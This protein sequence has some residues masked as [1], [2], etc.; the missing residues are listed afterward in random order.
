VPFFGIDEP[1]WFVVVVR[2]TD[3][4][5]APMFPIYPA[6]LDEAGNGTLADLVDGNV[7]EDGVMALGAT[8]A[9]YALPGELDP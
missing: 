2:G 4:V 3:D 9:L 5:C 1:T 7:G 8:N 6:D